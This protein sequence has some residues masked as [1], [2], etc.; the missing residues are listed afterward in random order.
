M[1]NMFSLKLPGVTRTLQT[2]NAKGFSV[3]LLGFT[4]PKSR[5]TWPF[6]AAPTGACKVSR[7]YRRVALPCS[8]QHSDFP[9]PASTEAW[10][11]ACCQAAC[12]HWLSAQGARCRGATDELAIRTCQHKVHAAEELPTSSQSRPLATGQPELAR[13][14]M[15]ADSDLPV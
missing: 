15:D 1:S 4:L 2:L 5:R 8:L 11:K 12:R 6:I 14:H 10:K 9:A 7:C 13:G 3:I